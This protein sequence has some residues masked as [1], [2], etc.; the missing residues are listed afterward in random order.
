MAK[1]CTHCG[2]EISDNAIVC[3]KCGCEVKLPKEKKIDPPIIRKARIFSAIGCCLGAIIP[4]T[5]SLIPNFSLMLC[6]YILGI[7][8]SQI[9]LGIGIYLAYKGYNET[10]MKRDLYASILFEVLYIILAVTL[11]LSQLYQYR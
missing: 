8:I 6:V 1:F 3:M 5:V 7:I 11:F 10:G 9:M 2:N 4:I